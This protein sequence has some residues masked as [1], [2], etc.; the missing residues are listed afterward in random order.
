MARLHRAL[1]QFMLDQHTLQHGYTEA[2]VPYLVNANTL[3]GTGQLPKFEEDLFRTAGDNPL[4][5]IPTAEVP[6]T[7][8]VADT[9]LDDAELPLRLVCAASVSGFGLGRCRFPRYLSILARG[10]TC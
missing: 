8:L 9:I 3:F 5:L 4:Y 2:Y 6:A 7:N 10:C 1:A